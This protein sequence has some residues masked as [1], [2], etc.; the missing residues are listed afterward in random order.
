[1]LEH[2]LAFA[3]TAWPE[4]RD[5]KRVGGGAKDAALIVAIEKYSFVAKVPG[6]GDN[7]DD[8]K[9]YLTSS[10]G[11]PSHNVFELRDA[12]VQPKTVVEKL[13]ET[14][15]RVEAGGT[16]WFVFIGHGA[17][18]KGGKDGLLVGVDARPAVDSLFAQSVRRSDV[19]KIAASSRATQ[20]MIVLDTCFSGR[21]TKGDPLIPGSQPL[22][23]EEI[24]AV[25]DKRTVLFTAARSDEFAGP[26]PGGNRPAFS[27]LV[28]GGL[29]GW[30]DA[31]GNG[32]VTVKELG[33]FSRR[34][35]TKFVTNRMQ[36]PTVEGPPDL[37]IGQGW[38]TQ[39]NIDAIV[40]APDEPTGKPAAPP[41]KCPPMMLPIAGG[42][43]K[44]PG[45]PTGITI[46]PFCLN[47]FEVTV[48]QYAHCSRLTKKPCAPPALKVNWPGIRPDERARWSRYC[49]DP[50]NK[51][52]ELHP[53]NCVTWAEANEY[54]HAY[55]LRLPSEYEWVWAARGGEA[56]QKYPWGN[57]EPAMQ[58]CW[59]H[60]PDKPRSGTCPTGSRPLGKS[61]DGVH[62]LVGNVWEWTSSLVSRDKLERIIQ[63]GGWF[64][65]LL[66]TVARSAGVDP[67]TRD[68]AVGFRCALTP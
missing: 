46:A 19:L 42:V 56:A 24:P 32:T 41:I 63:G 57:E 47:Q 51:D 28:L 40:R 27:Y 1:M 37:A 16:L 14:A 9:K 26:L 49:N 64:D 15:R 52:L 62:D 22:V 66:P 60:D 55:N 36:T 33:D 20:S 45:N 65:S 44:W 23:A 18:A 4:F 50:R 12:E 7:A 38:E 3:K 17:L 13:S 21:S 68:F 59:S 30:A 11:V 2:T 61:V 25:P 35:L 43:W 39:P 48:G 5:F 58:T 54:C 6:A 67:R 8:W 31:D 29:R 10:R 53:M 34:V